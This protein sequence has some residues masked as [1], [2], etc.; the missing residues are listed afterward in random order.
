VSGFLIAKRA[1]EEMAERLLTLASDDTLRA[2]FAQAGR[3][4]VEV[5]F[6]LEC[7]VKIFEEELGRGR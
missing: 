1:P 5:H 3:H 7:Q 6:D 4:R 2:R